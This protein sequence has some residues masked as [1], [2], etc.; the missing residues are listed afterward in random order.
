LAVALSSLALAD[1]VAGAT[2]RDSEEKKGGEEK[3]VVFLTDSDGALGRRL[4]S[5]GTVDVAVIVPY[6]YAPRS[7]MLSEFKKLQGAA[8]PRSTGNVAEIVLLRPEPTLMAKCYFAE[9]IRA[10][11]TLKGITAKGTCEA[12]LRWGQGPHGDTIAV[13]VCV[14]K[15]SPY[16]DKVRPGD[17]IQFLTDADG[18]LAKR[19]RDCGKVDLAIIEP[20]K[21]KSAACALSEFKRLIGK[22]PQGTDYFGEVVRFRQKTLPTA[23]GYF[24]DDMHLGAT[25]RDITAKG[26]CQAV[27]SWPR[28]NVTEKTVA[29]TVC[30]A[31]I[32]AYSAEIHP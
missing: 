1:Y 18:A 22:A 3:E 32:S 23:A 9:S 10:G 15:I 6:E 16:S 26:S 28:L 24:P 4:R 8:P 30:V 14:A 27:L 7:C 12:V 20:Y 29:L 17:E 2:A 13:T 31:K 5:G 25:L 21:Y 19:L 11:A